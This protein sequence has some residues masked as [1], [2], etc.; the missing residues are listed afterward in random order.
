[1]GNNVKKRKAGD[2]SPREKE[3]SAK[4]PR[5]DVDDEDDEIII[6]GEIRKTDRA[7]PNGKEKAEDFNF[8]DVLKLFR[9]ELQKL[10]YVGHPGLPH[11]VDICSVSVQT[12]RSI[13]D[14]VLSPR[15]TSE[16]KTATIEERGD[17]HEGLLTLSIIHSR[18]SI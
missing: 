7:H 5:A 6:V 10:R 13:S 9:L 3:N 2:P 14:S 12:Q 18:D 16:R 15:R 8:N 17:E 11:T 1:M 4:R